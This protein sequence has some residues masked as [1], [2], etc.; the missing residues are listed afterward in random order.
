LVPL[1]SAEV[2]AMSAAPADCAILTALPPDAT[3]SVPPL[4]M[5]VEVAEPPDDTDCVPPL[6]TT[7]RVAT[8]PFD[9][10]CWPRAPTVVP[11]S[12]PAT[13]SVPPAKVAESALAPAEIVSVPPLL[14]VVRTAEPPLL[15]RL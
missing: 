10:I 11:L 1:R 6:L 9:T 5:V 8:P 13:F 3:F 14:T 7:T 4:V 2:F 12:V 15:T